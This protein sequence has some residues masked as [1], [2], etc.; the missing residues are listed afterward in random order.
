MNRWG[1][2][3]TNNGVITGNGSDNCPSILERDWELNFGLG[4]TITAGHLGRYICTPI[5]GLNITIW[6]L[7]RVLLRAIVAIGCMLWLYKAVLGIDGGSN[8]ED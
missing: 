3:L 8:D 4:V 7:C 2:A 1:Q 5:G 6:A